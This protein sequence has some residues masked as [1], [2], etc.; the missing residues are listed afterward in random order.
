MVF[1]LKNS[2][3]IK[4]ILSYRSVTLLSNKFLENL[5]EFNQ[6]LGHFEQFIQRMIAFS[7][8]DP[9]NATKALAYYDKKVEALRLEDSREEQVSEKMWEF[10]E[11]LEWD[12]K[13]KKGLVSEEFILSG[14]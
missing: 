6:K 4:S 11:R 8:S 9:I 14:S 10:M 2:S 7:T 1:S 13:D 3:A 5:V 12:L